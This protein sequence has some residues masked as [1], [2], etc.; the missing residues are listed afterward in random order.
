MSRAKITDG[1]GQEK[2]RAKPG[3]VVSFACRPTVRTTKWTHMVM[4]AISAT[5]TKALRLNVFPDGEA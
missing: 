5:R 1:Q 2:S 4:P 3:N